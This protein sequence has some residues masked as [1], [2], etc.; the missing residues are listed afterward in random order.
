MIWGNT[1]FIPMSILGLYPFWAFLKFGINI[2][3]L[4]TWVYTCLFSLKTFKNH[5]KLVHTC[6]IPYNAKTDLE[7][8]TSTKDSYESFK[9]VHNTNTC[10]VWRILKKTPSRKTKSW[11]SN[12]TRVCFWVLITLLLFQNLWGSWVGNHPQEDLAKFDYWKCI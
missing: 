2:Y 9:K 10:L 11:Y 12:N 1:I 6:I 8:I 4:S 5:P 3:Q 7:P